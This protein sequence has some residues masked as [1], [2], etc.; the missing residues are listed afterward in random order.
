MWEGVL[1]AV[2]RRRTVLQVSDYKVTLYTSTSN[3]STVIVIPT[4]AGALTL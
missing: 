1:W 4:V 2:V 3:G